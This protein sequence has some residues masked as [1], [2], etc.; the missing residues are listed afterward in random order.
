ML[1]PE[2]LVEIFKNVSP[3]QWG[4]CRMVCKA[5]QASIDMGLIPQW[6]PCVQ[7]AIL[8]ATSL[9]ACRPLRIKAQAVLN[10]NQMPFGVLSYLNGTGTRC[11]ISFIADHGTNAMVITQA[12]SRYTLQYNRMPIPNWR[13][14]LVYLQSVLA[15]S[16]ALARWLLSEIVA[17]GTVTTPLI[18]IAEA[19]KARNFGCKTI[20]GSGTSPWSPVPSLFLTTD[21]A[22]HVYTYM[23]KNALVAVPRPP[24]TPTPTH[25]DVKKAFSTPVQMHVQHLPWHTIAA[26]VQAHMQTHNTVLHISFDVC[27]QTM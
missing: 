23:T 12:T 20:L 8:A 26:T 21:T 2:L 11:C 24:L 16:A 7:A 3:L 13:S 1:P 18:T 27:R 5:W 19:I 10:K 14:A 9:T 22:W 4:N 6:H 15:V 25:T 17:H